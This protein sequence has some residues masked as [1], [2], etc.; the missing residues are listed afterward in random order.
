GIVGLDVI[1]LVFL[2]RVLVLSVDQHNAF[3]PDLPNISKFIPQPIPHGKMLFSFVPVCIVGAIW[4]E[5]CFRGIP[6]SLGGIGWAWTL[7]AVAVSSTVFALHHLRQ[8]KTA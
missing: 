3:P 1:S 5:L 4:E 2:R 6:L 7:S 8:G